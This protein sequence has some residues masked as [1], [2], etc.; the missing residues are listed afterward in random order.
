MKTSTVSSLF[1]RKFTAL[2][3]NTLTR[4]KNE[5][6][7][8]WVIGFIFQNVLT[9]IHA[10]QTIISR[11][12]ASQT[13][14]SFQPFI[15]QIFFGIKFVVSKIY[16]KRTFAYEETSFKLLVEF[17]GCKGYTIFMDG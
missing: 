15:A 10:K 2:W 7:S 13:F 11:L 17:M 12:M 9:V 1:Y 8:Q 6:V 4:G 5:V 3:C 14:V 16:R